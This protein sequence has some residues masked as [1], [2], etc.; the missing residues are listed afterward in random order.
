VLT[1]V[2]GTAPHYLIA[3]AAP[4]SVRRTRAGD[5][6]EGRQGAPAAPS[7]GRTAVLLGMP[8]RS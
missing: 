3:D 2:T 4:L 7:G 1:Q 6:W 5:A 8:G